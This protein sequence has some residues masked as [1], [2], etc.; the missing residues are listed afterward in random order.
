[1]MLV[2]NET[3][4][5]LVGMDLQVGGAN[6][7]G[8][9]EIWVVVSVDGRSL[10]DSAIESIPVGFLDGATSLQELSVLRRGRA[11][12]LY[13]SR[14]DCIGVR[15]DGRMCAFL[16]FLLRCILMNDCAMGQEPW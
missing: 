10:R 9:A 2:F 7:F 6:G 5:G 14:W 13:A 11:R 3:V 16:G 12:D 8:D 1:M 15:I 4:F